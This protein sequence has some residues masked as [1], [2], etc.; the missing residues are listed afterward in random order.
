[1]SALW[2]P[3]WR[4]TAAC[5]A[6]G[7]RRGNEAGHA[8]DLGRE[9]TVAHSGIR[10]LCVYLLDAE[11]CDIRRHAGQS[12]RGYCATAFDRLLSGR[13]EVA[14]SFLSPRD[15]WGKRRSEP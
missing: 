8:S 10:I 11:A 3:L 9:R 1:M 6:A 15:L 5:S 4:G 12:G 7:A 2:R 14:I 13:S